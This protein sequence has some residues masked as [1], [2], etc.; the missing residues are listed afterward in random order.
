MLQA[1]GLGFAAHGVT[2]MAETE[3][4]LV[5]LERTQA[6]L[7]TLEAATPRLS[8]DTEDHL[9]RM[10]DATARRERRLS[11]IA[12]RVLLEARH[13]AGIRRTPFAHNATGKPSLPGY[14]AAFSLSHTRGRA[15]VAVGDCEVLG[16]DIER[17]R[18]V[19]MPP[20]RRAPIEAEAVALAAGAALRGDG[21]D[22]RFLSAW[23]RIEAAA[24]AQGRGVGAVLERLRPRHAAAARAAPRSEASG[25]PS[26][27]VYDVPVAGDLFAAVALPA[28]H[29]PPPLRTLP[30][31]SGAIAALLSGSPGTRR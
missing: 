8:R 1:L 30:Q 15:L 3:L 27:A 16:V 18:E 21:A 26:I 19:R 5:D 29:A 14:D 23:V 11:H 17:L 31:A 24:K 25:L 7:E 28:G 12:L 13:G 22:A 9:D 2:T 4:W 6:A 20:L 10:A